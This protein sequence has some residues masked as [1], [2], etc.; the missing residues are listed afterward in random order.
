MAQIVLSCFVLGSAHKF[1]IDICK[2]N[3]VTDT[4][5]TRNVPIEILTFDH[6]KIMIWNKI[7]G[8]IINRAYQLKL[9]KIAISRDKKNMELIALNKRIHSSIDIKELGDELDS[10]DTFNSEDFKSSNETIHFIIVQP[11]LPTITG[12]CLFQ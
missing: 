1:S 12:M 10:T 8:E 2:L 9:F 7:N 3:T 11:P 4:N 5:G 6:I